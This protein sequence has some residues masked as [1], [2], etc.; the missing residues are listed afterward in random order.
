MLIVLHEGF[1][2]L[3]RGQLLGPGDKDQGFVR[4]FST[5]NLSL[6]KS[7]E[8]LL[9]ISHFPSKIYLHREGTAN[10]NGSH[11][12]ILG[13]RLAEIPVADPIIGLGKY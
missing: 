7:I 13:N 9:V 3:I 5:K 6:I 12:S 1:Q 11:I 8:I 10:L 4:G 2:S